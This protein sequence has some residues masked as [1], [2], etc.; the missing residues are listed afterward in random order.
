MRRCDTYYT[1]G[2]LAHCFPLVLEIL[3]SFR[4]LLGDARMF[5]YP[6]SARQD[7]PHR[8]APLHIRFFA[9]GPSSS[10][11]SS[12]P[13]PAILYIASSCCESLNFCISSSRAARMFSRS[14]SG[15]PSSLSWVSALPRHLSQL[16]RTETGVPYS[17]ESSGYIAAGLGVNGADEAGRTEPTH[18]SRSSSSMYL[19]S[20]G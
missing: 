20:K 17:R 14:I 15:S 13:I 8:S 9:L 16:G 7:N 19:P 10:S 3:H 4:R 2:T 11:S 6:R 18:S 12:R 1:L 5:P